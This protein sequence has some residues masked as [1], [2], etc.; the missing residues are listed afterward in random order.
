MEYF[1]ISQD[2]RYTHP[3]VITNLND[4]IQRRTQ[5]SEEEAQEVADINVAFAKPEKTLDFVDV[6][7]SQMFLVGE[8]VRDVFG[9]YEPLLTF[10]SVCILNNMTGDYRNYYAPVFRTI[11]CYSEK[12]EANRNRSIIEKLV[13]RESEIR[14]LGIFKVGNVGT[15][16]VVIRLDVAERPL[17]RGICQFWLERVQ[18]EGEKSL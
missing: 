9:M 18:L 8:Q 6:L 3:P 14:N 12:S 16:V 4:I 10:K 15:E 11:D 7:D 1:R 13:L 2:K 17:R 5:L